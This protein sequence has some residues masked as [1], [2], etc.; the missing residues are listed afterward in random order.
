[1]PIGF[2]TVPGGAMVRT[3]TPLASYSLITGGKRTLSTYQ[4]SVPG[5]RTMSAG[6]VTPGVGKIVFVG[7][8][9]TRRS[10][11]LQSA[12]LVGNGG[13]Y[14]HTLAAPVSGTEML[15]AASI[16]GMPAGARF[17]WRQQ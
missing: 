17:L 6:I 8:V 10:T 12:A 16:A 14:F 1:M 5:T 3:N 15:P 13:E 2:F 4:W 9:V 7:G 11:L